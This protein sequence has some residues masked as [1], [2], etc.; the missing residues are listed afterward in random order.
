LQI[1][2]LFLKRRGPA[3]RAVAVAR[4]INDVPADGFSIANDNYSRCDGAGR[5]I[6]GAGACRQADRERCAKK[7]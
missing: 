1:L 3:V 6:G 7:Q 2:P 4:E 5:C